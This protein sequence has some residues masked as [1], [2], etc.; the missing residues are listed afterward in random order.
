[1]DII[2]WNTVQSKTSLFIKFIQEEQHQ[3]EFVT[4]NAQEYITVYHFHQYKQTRNSWL[5][6]VVTDYYIKIKLVA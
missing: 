3:R 2:I 1:M 5:L 4:T 6:Q